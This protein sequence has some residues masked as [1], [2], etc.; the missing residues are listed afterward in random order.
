MPN[1]YANKSVTKAIDNPLANNWPTDK[2]VQLQTYWELEWWYKMKH[3][4]ELL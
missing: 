2:K 4:V 1:N 3:G